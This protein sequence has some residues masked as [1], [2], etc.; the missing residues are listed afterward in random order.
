MDTL[1]REV[2][3]PRLSE[4]A[5]GLFL[6]LCASHSVAIIGSSYLDNGHPK[7]DSRFFTGIYKVRFDNPV[8]LQSFSSALECT[9]IKM[10]KIP[11]F[12]NQ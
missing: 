7:E 4:K 10:K 8:K 3:I 12:Q 5:S 11:E 2:Q 9:N 1:Y 6:K